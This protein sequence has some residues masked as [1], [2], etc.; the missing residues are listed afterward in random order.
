M[1]TKRFTVGRFQ[2]DE[3]TQ[4]HQ[5]IL[6]ELH[7]GDVVFVGSANASFSKRNPLPVAARMKM[8]KDRYPQ[9]TILPIND[10]QDDRVWAQTIDSLLDGIHKWEGISGPDGFK[11]TYIESG[12]KWPV[13]TIQQD[14]MLSESTRRR[15]DIGSHLKIDNLDKRQALIWTAHNLRDQVFP[16]VDILCFMR[17]P[18]GNYVLVGQKRHEKLF[19]FPG[20]FVDLKDADMLSAAKREFSEEVPNME[21]AGWYYITSMKI[22]DWRFKDTQG[23]MTTIFECEY[24]FGYPTAGDDLAQVR[25]IKLKDLSPDL[26]VPAHRPI[27]EFIMR[28]YDHESCSFN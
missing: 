11:R 5:R 18:V 28:T 21:V 20:G 9:L 6:S 10:Y 13:V 19:R 27:C 17:S 14:S 16:T 3:P 24:A 2:T 8:L 23:I 25:W 1:A 15:E 7:Y 12:G 26:F 4:G 22:N